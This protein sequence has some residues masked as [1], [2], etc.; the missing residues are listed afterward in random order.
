MK[1]AWVKAVLY[2][3][4]EIAVEAGQPLDKVRETYGEKAHQAMAFEA[5]RSILQDR[6]ALFYREDGYEERVP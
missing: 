5:L 3:E 6:P 2:V 4:H 1:I